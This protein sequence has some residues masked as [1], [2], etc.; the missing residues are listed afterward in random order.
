MSSLPYDRERDP[1]AWTAWQLVTRSD[2]HVFLTGKAGTGKSTFV[3]RLVEAGVKRTALLAYTAVAARNIGGQTINSF[4]Q[5]RPQDVYRPGSAALDEHSLRDER[6]RL[7][8]SLDLIVV[9]EVSM[10]RADLFDA[11]DARLRQIRG[12]REPFGGVQMLLVGDLRQLPPVTTH[13][14][15]L[16]FRECHYRSPY[17]FSASVMGRLEGRLVTVALKRVYRQSDEAFLGILNDMRNHVPRPATLE[18]LN[19]RVGT[20]DPDA[21]RISCINA[22]VNAYNAARLAALAGPDHVYQ[23]EITDSFPGDDPVDRRLRLRV[24]ARVMFAKNNQPEGYYNGLLGEVTECS[25][26]RVTVRTAD[27]ELEVG[28]ARWSNLE[29]RLGE[30]G[31]MRQVET[32]AY[33][34][35]PLRLAWA[36]TVH[37]SQGLT[38]DKLTLDL[39]RAFETG[40]VYVALSRCR[41]L[42][43]LTL[44]APLTPSA[45][46][47]D[48][49]VG[50]Y[51]DGSG[52]GDLCVGPA[53]ADRL[54][55][56]FVGQFHTRLLA[57]LFD[58]WPLMQ[59][60]NQALNVASRSSAKKSADKM[61]LVHV[62][63][64]R[65]Q[66]L[67]DVGVRF[68]A[69]AR[70]SGPDPRAD[71]ALC[72]RVLA[73]C[74]YFS[75]EVG[76]AAGALPKLL[77]FDV[78][79][80]ELRGRLVKLQRE[81]QG[82]YDMLLF[83]W[84]RVRREGFDAAVVMHARA[85]CASGHAHDE[86]EGGARP[87]P[88]GCQE[89]AQDFARATGLANGKVR[90]ERKGR[91]G[92][93]AKGMASSQVGDV[94]APSSGPAPVQTE[95]AEVEL[96][97][98]D[99]GAEASDKRYAELV[100]YFLSSAARK[101]AAARQAVKGKGDPLA[102]ADPCAVS[103]LGP[104]RARR[105]DQALREWRLR[106]AREMRKPAYIVLSNRQLSAVVEHAPRTLDELLALPG[107][108]Q[109]KVEQVGQALIELVEAV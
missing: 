106:Q 8:R 40:Q 78:K 70:Q 35:I 67:H 65:L 99:P 5:I 24:G 95:E 94:K 104:D 80:A 84:R 101:A 25:D 102:S 52:R 29:Y 16:A 15:Q 77:T 79:A 30:G 20:P 31:E 90:K 19:R 46:R 87:V 13:S 11:M 73:G 63:L 66:E 58:L 88:P 38:F 100:K 3:R 49:A 97:P 68:A 36:I 26:G 59:P 93:E 75:R 34:Q 62:G 22:D 47:L 23:A 32:G 39:S 98:A 89:G 50:E 60:L 81:A 45:F 27:G 76:A 7:I 18:L 43:G 9:D 10:V 64:L 74:D 14:D 12:S 44:L 28:P 107:F 17:F 55:E 72:A 86:E 4:L 42:E 109:V 108:G 48:A 2:V 91:K 105:L 41:S 57:D 96:T 54:V 37:K 85:L 83:V 56:E 21:V 33:R 51:L 61:S 6:R 82:A 69:E 71:A 92:R 53:N 1:D 103:P